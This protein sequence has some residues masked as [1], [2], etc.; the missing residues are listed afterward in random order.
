MAARPDL[1]MAGPKNQRFLHRLRNALAGVGHALRHERSFRFHSASVVAVAGLLAW[2]RPGAA[3]VALVALASALVIA[4]ELLNTALEAL[5]DHLH[6]EQHE[7]IRIAKD[8]AA[9][10]VLAA[11]AGALAVAAAMLLDLAQR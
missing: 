3:W 2:L 11:A 8:C 7:K 4:A 9:G 5:A 10:A 6:P 1:L